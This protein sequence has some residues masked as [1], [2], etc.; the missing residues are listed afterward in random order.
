MRKSVLALAAFSAFSNLASAQS[1]VVLAGNVDAG[2][3]RVGTATGHDWGLGGSGSPGNR[4]IFRG[5]ED[6]GGGMRAGFRL[7]HRFVIGNGVNNS[8]TNGGGADCDTLTA[9]AQPCTDPF[10][11]RAF[12][13][14]TM[15]LGELRLGRQ[16]GPLQEIAGSYEPFETYTLGSVNTGGVN[17]AV[18]NNSQ[19][20]YR[21][22][23]LGGLVV[24]AAIAEATGQNQGVNGQGEVGSSLLGV[25]TR[26]NRLGAERPLGIAV[27]YKAGRLSV[28]GGWDRNA[29]DLKTIGLY[30]AYDFG[31]FNLMAQFEKGDSDTSFNPAT[32]VEESLKAFSFGARV[33]FGALTAKIGAVKWNSDLANRDGSKF[34]V[35]VDYTLSKRTVAYSDIGKYSGDRFSDAV[36]K[37]RFDLGVRHSF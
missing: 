22:P 15:P 12:I 11:R 27:E 21:S 36:K 18:R 1:Q 17:A 20:E 8:P 10:Y 26:R 7:E 25:F 37:T 24:V 4:I 29:G 2:V 19:I 6:L 30:G 14:L 16:D 31:G 5:N 34:G 9:G 3:R 23:N 28:G 32:A 33:P 35:G 13:S